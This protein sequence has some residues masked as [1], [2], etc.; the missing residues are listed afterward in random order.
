MGRRSFK[1]FVEQELGGV[2]EFF[3]YAVLEWVMIFMLFIGGF[4]AFFAY[5]FARFFELPIPCFLCARLDLL[6]TNDDRCYN[7]SICDNHKK[8]ASCLAFCHVHKRLSDIR[9]L[10]ESCLLS[11]ATE[12][13]TD[14]NRYKSLL[15]I[16]HKDVDQLLVDENNNEVHHSLPPASDAKRDER[17]AGFERSNEHRCTC[18]GHRLKVESTGSKGRNSP[19]SS[20]AP[21]PSADHLSPED[22]DR[23][24]GLALDMPL[25]EDGKG[26]PMPMV[27]EGDEEDKT[28][29]SSKFFGI[30]LSDSSAD[31][32][33]WAAK[34]P[35]KILLHTSEFAAADCNDDGHTPSSPRM[36]RKSLM[37]LYMELD[38]ERNASA[39]AA[40]N[41]M[42]MITRLQAEKAAVQMEAFQYQ[43]MMEEQAE[44][45]QET[46]EE[47]TN[48]VAK[49]EEELND[50]EI[51][52]EVY[53]A[54]YGRLQESD[55]E[56]HTQR[57]ENDE[58]N[59]T[60]INDGDT[61]TTSLSSSNC[62]KP[63]TALTITSRENSTTQKDHHQIESEVE[64][65]EAAATM[66]KTK[67]VGTDSDPMA[68]KTGGEATA[69]SKKAMRQMDRMKI[70]EK[71]MHISTMGRFQRQNSEIGEDFDE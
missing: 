31:S 30:P 43:R 37:A 40:Y 15:G 14:C 71:K 35:R 4:V 13:E 23:S 38:E 26:G 46:L 9:N 48:L 1:Q 12:R 52:L 8:S 2:P 10:C 36:G 7:E 22:N 28:A 56:K 54:K 17:P 70:L 20:L 49:R 5:E 63:E 67:K 25:K 16:L 45:D 44:Y 58:L 69:K 29:K 57:D 11:F 55:F 32:P 62:D 51:E 18:C 50:L 53:R 68:E 24:R 27:P 33:R 61:K 3:I 66:D 47:M 64:P 39:V 34:T 59:T 65:A 42:A 41:A 19:L 60:T 21:S 6:G